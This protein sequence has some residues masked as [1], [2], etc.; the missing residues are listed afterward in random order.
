M[1]GAEV[2]EVVFQVEEAVAVDGVVP[3]RG[4][5]GCAVGQDVIGGEDA[6]GV[7]SFVIDPVHDVLGV[8]A[9]Q[10]AQ[11]DEDALAFAR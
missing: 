3:A 4:F 1:L 8:G 2:A 5:L 11:E 9:V 10:A 7:G 6:Q